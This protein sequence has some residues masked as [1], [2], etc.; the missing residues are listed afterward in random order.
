VASRRRSARRLAATLHWLL[1]S[2]AAAAPGDAWVTYRGADGP[3]LGRTIVLVSGDEEYRSEEALPQ[4]GR[5]LAARHGFTCVVLF[6]VDPATGAI[7]PEVRTNIPGLEALADADLL[8]IATRFRDLPDAQMRHVDDYLRRGGPV[9]GL[10]TATHAFALESSPTYRR[11]S[12]NHEGDGLDGGFGRQVLGETWIAHHGRHGEQSTRGILADGARDHPIARGLADGDVWGPTDVYRVRL[13]LPDGCGPIVLGQVLAG[14]TPDDPP[15]AGGPNDPMMPVAWTRAYRVPGG[16]PGRVFTTTMG[17]ATDLV[18]EGTRRMLVNA[19][20]WAVGL[21]DRI[22]PDGADVRLVGGFDPSPF[23]FGGHRRGVRPSDHAW[24]PDDAPV[25][26]APAGRLELAPGARVAV[27]GN[28]FAERLAQSGWLDALAHAAHPDHRLVIRH[29]PWS[30]DEVAVRPREMNVPGLEDHL[31]DLAPDV[32]VLCFGMSE[33]FAGP[34]G[35]PAFETA[36]AE[37]IATA[38]GSGATPPPDVVLVSPIAHE[39]RGPPGEPATTVA[40]R[41]RVLARYVDTARVVAGDH[42]A[43]FVDLFAPPGASP[44]DARCTPLRSPASSG[45][46]RTR[47]AGPGRPGPGRWTSC[48]SSRATRTGTSG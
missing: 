33:S 46:S 42:G 23:A 8:V 7:D 11:W 9:V 15:V 18:A 10:R 14:M 4:L 41:N 48:A 27:A 44:R 32:V 6:A 39:D 25:P 21:G 38:R 19:V 12:W 5:I 30:G 24:P 34:D 2:A 16:R 37:L 1:A 31:A 28:T 22:P 13:P 20:Y 17:A 35:L 26:G 43:W 29:V 36:L 3:G 47:T 40:A 45:G